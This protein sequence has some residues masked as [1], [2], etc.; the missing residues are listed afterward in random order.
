MHKKE[1][2]ET[3]KNNIKVKSKVLP[4]DKIEDKEKNIHSLLQN[5]IAL[6][7]TTA[8]LALELKNLN[9]KVA[10]IVALFE[11][12]STAFKEGDGKGLQTE[13]K[14]L[15]DKLDTIIDQNKT[16]AKGIVL[17]EQNVRGKPASASTTK[18]R[19]SIKRKTEEEDE[20]ETE[21]EE[22]KEY[23]PQP[24]PEFTF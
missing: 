16:I 19:P 10:K 9:Q 22:D 23:K 13:S 21:N 8:D 24:L 5:S 7:K 11:S 3:G 18:M 15:L 6:Q 2:K 14:E 12:A 4:K 1:M 20:E 17:L